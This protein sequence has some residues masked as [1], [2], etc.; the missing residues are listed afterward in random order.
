MRFHYFLQ[1]RIQSA[2]G[3]STAM[4]GWLI[5][6][7]LLADEITMSVVQKGTFRGTFAKVPQNVKLNVHL[8]EH[9]D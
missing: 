1:K 2:W 6:Q 7:A 8:R 9:F 3:S 4:S 5:S